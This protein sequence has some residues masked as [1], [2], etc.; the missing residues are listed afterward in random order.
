MRKARLTGVVFL[1]LLGAVAVIAAS[2]IGV[3]GWADTR[4]QLNRS[5][6]QTEAVT[7]L[8]VP[9]LLRLFAPSSTPSERAVWRFFLEEFSR[10][11]KGKSF[12]IGVDSVTRWPEIP[13]REAQHLYDRITHGSPNDPGDPS[14]ASAVHDFILK[15]SRPAAL[16]AEAVPSN[17]RIIPLRTFS[18]DTEGRDGWQRFV[19]RN[20]VVAYVS[21][22]RVG[23]TPRGDR[24][25]IYL[26]LD[27]GPLC[28]HGA[29]YVLK[30]TA[31]SWQVVGEHVDWVS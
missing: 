26:Q 13:R 17:V 10:G 23:F 25:V 30:R 18:V 6:A 9:W 24:A 3:N 22:S 14:F 29:Y 2:L 28:G 20:R 19:T 4:D 21:F 12:V 16:L 15:N 27:C 8:R 7:V 1:T 5:A 11:P 31:K